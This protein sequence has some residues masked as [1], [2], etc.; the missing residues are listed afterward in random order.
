MPAAVAVCDRI[1]PGQA[2][3]RQSVTRVGQIL[4]ERGLTALDCIPGM[5]GLTT[6]GGLARGL[7][8]LA[9]TGL[10]GVKQGALGLGRRLRGDGIPMNGRNA[11]GDPVDVATGELLMSAV[12]VE[13]PGVLPLVLERHHIS[14][15][16][17]GR[18]FGASW[19]STL[20]QRLV[21]EE[22]GARLL[23]ADGMTLLYPRP[24]PD[25]PVLPVEGPR[26]PLSWDG[27]WGAP[28]SVHQPATGR[29]LHFAPAEGRP[30]AELPLIAITDRNAN[31]IHLAYDQHGAPT[32]I[33][34][35]GGYHLG[36]TTHKHRITALTLL[37]D[38]DRPTLLR[39]GYDSAGLLAEIT[40]SSGRPLKFSYDEH[41]RMSRWEDRN[42]YWY[43]Y[44]YDT[45]GRCVFTTGTDRALEYRYAYDPDQLRTVV[46]DSLGHETRYQFNDSFQ[47]IAQTDPL[48]HTIT[49]A[50]DR[51]D[52][53]L[54]ITDPLGHTTRHTHDEHGNI[55]TITRP[56]G[57]EVRAE[58]NEFHQPTEVT[59]PDGAVWRQSYDA[60]GNRTTLL[61]P[62]GHRTRY[63]YDKHGAVA[64]IV[65]ALGQRT[66]VRSDA[67][68]LPIAVT[69]PTGSVTRYERDSFGRVTSVTD[70]AGLV[71]LAERTVEGWLVRQIDPV[72]GEQ[73]WTYDGEGNRLTHTTADGRTTSFEYGAFD[74]PVAQT[75]PD[76]TRYEFVLDTELRVIKVIN[77]QGLTWDYTYDPVGRLIAES[78]FD[79]RIVR[80]RFDARGRL[81]ERTNGVGQ[82]VVYVRDALGRMAEKHMGGTVTSFSYDARGRL[83]RAADEE[84]EL[85]VE[86][87]PLGRV[88]SE[89]VNGRAV[90]RTYDPLG[91]LVGR[92]TPSGHR[93]THSYDPAGRPETLVAAG[94]AMAFDYDAAGRETS[95]RLSTDVAIGQRWDPAGRLVGQ[96]VSA[97]GRTV[98]ERDYGYREDGCVTH[99][100]EGSGA[101]RMALD[102]H[103]RVLSID[104]AAGAEGY[105]YDRAGNQI[106]GQWPTGDAP[107]VSAGERDYTG[108]R[109]TRAGR[110]RY[111]Y[112]E[113][114]RTIRRRVAR[115]SGKVDT[116][117]YEWDA[118]D[119][120]TTVTTPDGVRWRYAYDPFGRRIAKRRHAEDGSVA[121]ETLFTWSGTTLVEQAT[122]RG[123]ADESVLTWDYLGSRPLAQTER[124]PQQEVGRRFYAIVTDIV[125]TPTDLVDE[126][127]DVVWHSDTTVWGVSRGSA[128]SQ[129][130]ST[131]LRFPG[132]TA[133][134]ETGWHYNLHRHYDPATARYTTPDPYGLVPAPNHYAYVDHPFTWSDPLGLAP[135]DAMLDDVSEAYV[136]RRHMPGGSEA[137]SDK[138]TFLPDVDLDDLVDQANNVPPRGPNANGN[139][140]R[141]V[142]A[143]GIIG[144]Q[145]PDAGGLPSSR[146][147]VVQDYYGGV[148]TMHPL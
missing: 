132:Q 101:S 1:D 63:A 113:A 17:A 38:P 134:E 59:Q 107:A 34:H 47:L 7:R 75:R 58:Y 111:Q 10:K 5:K 13:L 8:G 146:Y 70:P 31:R 148:I 77:P 100:D 37:N 52:R 138:S 2:A 85:L 43:S 25:E 39:Y 127:G 139:W 135:H 72:A 114:G 117:R 53:T 133:D 6:L 94:T 84:V 54:A 88:L 136:R 81:T 29:T 125:G 89:A 15:Y 23:T 108:M 82:S 57:S 45:Q 110:V 120:L 74:L 130:A 119:R 60:A 87:D 99:I 124:L 97:G 51:Y 137:T 116:W 144:H 106:F 131:P 16:R 40:N 62:A 115:L 22:H 90:A 92:S 109:I 78:D 21:L 68:G 14:S 3:K 42:G 49:H 56:D 32:D 61:D 118:E 98:R 69:D 73:R 102:A 18:W 145:S 20:D 12:D 36:I 121:E 67:A 4:Y 50:W 123:D 44:D 129:T 95:R 103:G 83:L 112:D 19:A 33:H 122:R 11:C 128:G 46:T 126:A 147:R 55:T 105:R 30:G 65:D 143:D 66:R 93:S 27:E 142:D 86:R 28:M 140:E 141:D 79:G 26:W 91:R 64:M 104:S 35:S 96:H 48:G 24:I 9:S 76:G 80:Y 71:T 41:R